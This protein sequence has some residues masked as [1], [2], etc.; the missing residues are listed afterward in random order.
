MQV[1]ILSTNKDRTLLMYRHCH[2][3]PSSLS[4]R[5]KLRLPVRHLNPPS[6]MSPTTASKPFYNQWLARSTPDPTWESPR[7]LSESFSTAV[8]VMSGPESRAPTVDDLQ[9]P[10]H[11]PDF[12]SPP[13]AERFGLR[14][15]VPGQNKDELGHIWKFPTATLNCEGP[16]T[17]AKTCC[18][19]RLPAWF[20]T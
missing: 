17:I 20:Y 7:E 10:H 12:C 15:H 3:L 1:S 4:I 13:S 8:I 5:L 2:H 6:N 14:R 11:S 19:G 18:K 16:G 9:P